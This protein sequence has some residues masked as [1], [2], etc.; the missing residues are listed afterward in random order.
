MT[1]FNDLRQYID[2][3]KEL[4]ELKL[5]EG[6][7]WD[8]EIGAITEMQAKPNTP[9]LL[10][11]K[12]KGYNAGYRV[13]TNLAASLKRVALI[14][15]LP[16]EM[17]EGQAIDLVRA[18]RGRTKQ[19]IVPIPPR[20]LETGPV[21]EN[22]HR[23][24]DVD[25]FEFPTPKWHELDGG[26][27]IGTGDM[28][29]IRDP[30]GGWVNLGTH[31]VQIHDKTT[32]TISMAPGS[33]NDILRR[34]YWAKGKACP[35]AVSCGQDPLL[36][37]VSTVKIPWGISEY[38]YTGWLRDKPVDVIQGEITDLPIPA[39]AEIV[40]EGEIPPPEIETRMEGP[41]GEFTGYYV[42]LKPEPVFRVKCILHRNNPILQGNTEF[43]IKPL[44]YWGRNI[45]RAA[46][47]WHEMEKR[48]TGIEGVW[49]MEE[50]AHTSPVVSIKQQ[51][52]GHAKE[53]GLAA[54]VATDHL[55]K[56][57]IVVDDDIDPSN[58]SEVLWA[59]GTRWD[60]ETGTDIIRGTRG[61]RLDPLLPPEKRSRGEFTGSTAILTAC[62]P[63]SRIKDF[64]VR[65]EASQDLMKKIR[66]GW[67]GVLE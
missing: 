30:D 45:L 40:L 28:V 64:P 39:S 38:D 22:I 31:R 21:K 65:A 20:T 61:S 16:R 54:K 32:A 49:I 27:Y 10:F 17:G 51:Y 9:L 37:L 24:G 5:I 12:I 7:D 47:I 3:V 67:K 44:F 56:L 63:Y 11:D 23:N 43:R 52:P 18:I 29:I 58:L 33:H 14:L 66:K 19:G 57:V 59:L 41:F 6:A 8:L 4:G 42:G 36:W 25:L 15:G 50:T 2:A 46:E 26:R 60:P 55:C 1:M 34:R 48:I 53:A 62:K 35:A 13:V